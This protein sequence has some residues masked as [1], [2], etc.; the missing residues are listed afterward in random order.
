VPLCSNLSM[1]LMEQIILLRRMLMCSIIQ[2]G[3][4]S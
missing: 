3:T 1:S 2:H 4:T